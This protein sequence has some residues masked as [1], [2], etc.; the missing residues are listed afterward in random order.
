[1]I[2]VLS[3]VG[4]RGNPLSRWFGDRK[5]GTK[6][7]IAVLVAVA[8]LGVQGGN[9]FVRIGQLANA[10]ERMYVNGAQPLGELG[11][12]RTAVGSMRQRVLLHVAGPADDKDRREEEIVQL[13]ARFDDYI[14]RYADNAAN[15]GTLEAYTEAVAAYRVFRDQTILPRSNAGAGA[16][17]VTTILAECDRCTPRSSCS[18]E[19]LD[20]EQ[21]AAVKRDHGAG[22]R[23]GDERPSGA[24]SSCC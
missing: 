14:G 5:V 1:M 15:P 16:A 21:V 10:A 8:F 3:T 6:V 4:R 19:Q 24:R 13:D 18:G 20:A 12:A 9:D 7:L 17:E 2:T 11:G 22:Q 23:A